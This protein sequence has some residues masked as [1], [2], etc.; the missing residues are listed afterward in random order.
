MGFGLLFIGYFVATLMS[1]HMFG[2]FVSVVGYGI[3]I[4]ASLKLSKYNNFFRL[5]SVGAAAMMA[6]YAIIAVSDI[7]D[8]LYSEMLIS[9]NIFTDTF[10]SVLEYV[11]IAANFFFV[12]ALLFSIRSIAKE[13][14]VF[15]LVYNSTRN[16][17]FWCVYYVLI[18]IGRLPFPFTEDYI[19]AF[20]P[21]SI[22]LYFVCIVLNLVLIFSCYAR[23][24]DEN[25]VDMA[26]KPSRFKFVNRFREE[27]EKRRE[28]AMNERVAYE[29]ERAKRK[30]KNK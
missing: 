28:K 7:G 11:D 19:A 17:T 25:D 13:T 6:V 27:S 18:L 30:R 21:F 16:L 20:G 3:I 15:K 8:F 26:Q 22:A 12:V 1:F 9:K 29:A 14:E 4:G 5:L 23:I 24:C 10:D 2:A